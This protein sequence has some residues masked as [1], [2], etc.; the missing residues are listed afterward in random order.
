[1]LLF[2]HVGITAAAAILTDAAFPLEIVRDHQF[3]LRY[4]LASVVSKIRDRTGKLDYRM[5]IIG[6]MLPDIIDKPLFIL[7]NQSE[8][9]TGRSHAHTLLFAL[10]LLSGG[11]LSRKSWLLTLALA[12]LFHLVLDSMWGTPETLFWPF[13]GR[14]SPYEAEGWFTDLWYNLTHLPEIYVPEIIGLIVT[15]FLAYKIIKVGG[16]NKF[17]KQGLIS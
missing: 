8:L 11:L 4:R 5:I 6:S 2:G 16:L 12:N 15:F 13:L 7:F 1:M 10:L 9:F 3:G 17:M 14:F